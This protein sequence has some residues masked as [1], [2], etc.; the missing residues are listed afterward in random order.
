MLTPK[1]KVL[2]TLSKGPAFEYAYDTIVVSYTKVST[3]LDE[4]YKEHEEIIKN[5][6][7]DST[8]LNIEQ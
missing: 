1:E 4:L 7:N 2:D 5:L 3:L 6:N 8:L